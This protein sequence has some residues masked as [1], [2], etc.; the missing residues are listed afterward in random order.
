MYGLL[1]LLARF[2]MAQRTGVGLHS[3]E[4]HQI[5]PSLSDDLLQ[6]QLGLLERVKVIQ[7]N[8]F[9]EWVLVRDLDQLRMADLYRSGN[10]RVPVASVALPF[11]DDAIGRCAVE[12]LNRLRDPLSEGL[13]RTLGDV[14]QSLPA[15]A[16]PDDESP[17]D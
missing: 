12:A 8:E 2:A 6:R 14:F 11:A 7:R 5:E 16:T 13:Q 4:L 17:A 9:G 3:N 1:R 10:L 15:S